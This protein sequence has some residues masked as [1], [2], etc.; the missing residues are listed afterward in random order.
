MRV[1]L[2]QIKSKN[3]LLCNFEIYYCLIQGFFLSTC[4]CGTLF[5]CS[6][7]FALYTCSIHELAFLSSQKIKVYLTSAKRRR[8]KK[9]SRAEHMACKLHSHMR[10]DLPVLGTR[11]QKRETERVASSTFVIYI[12]LPSCAYIYCCCVE[13]LI[14]LGR[15][16]G[17]G[18]GGNF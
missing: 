12:L 17:R 1:Q 4:H 2:A 16:A 15:C 5:N 3:L 11:M 6:F 7:L 9:K 18:E 8:S 14:L 13:T 10:A